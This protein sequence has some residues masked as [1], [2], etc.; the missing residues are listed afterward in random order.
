MAN[1]SLDADFIQSDALAPNIE[2]PQAEPSGTGSPGYSQGFYHG[3]SMADQKHGKT[4]ENLF[5][6]L[7]LI[8]LCC[9]CYCC[10][11][12]MA[13]LTYRSKKED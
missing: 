6:T 8:L 13:Y 3:Y 12:S 2:I 10:C 1:D 5:L 11:S 4:E 9:C 7:L